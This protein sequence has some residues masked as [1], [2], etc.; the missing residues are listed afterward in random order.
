MAINENIKIAVARSAE[1]GQIP[2]EI[3]MST[4]TQHHLADELQRRIP[5]NYANPKHITQRG[6]PKAVYASD[7]ARRVPTELT[8]GKIRVLVRIRE[9]VATDTF[10]L[11]FKALRKQI[12]YKSGREE[13][14][15]QTPGR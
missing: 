15:A 14:V 2:T 4:V 5:E 12:D 6:K 10:I 9:S 7:M 11:D 1:R 3:F 13:Y 8:F